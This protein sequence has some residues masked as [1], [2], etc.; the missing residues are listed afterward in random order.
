MNI[1]EV[2]RQFGLKTREITLYL[3]NLELGPTTVSNLARKTGIKR[4]TIYDIFLGLSAKGLMQQTKKGRKRLI[5]AADPATLFTLLNEKKAALNEVMPLL[6][7]LISTAGSKPSAQY[8]EGGEGLKEIYRDTLHYTGELQAFVSENII[9]LL[10]RDFSN[11]YIK[12]RHQQKIV[13]RAIGPDTSELRAYKKQDRAFLK[14]TRLVEAR[15][16]PFSIEMNIYGNKVAFM[17][18]KE[19]I[20][21]IIESNDIA[22]NMRLL[23]ELAWRGSR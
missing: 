15:K 18:F 1:E 14:Q 11:E 17:S 3:G 20:G 8:Y 19:K 7:S 13:V 6:K 10:G 23:F 16:F 5:S 21:I 22:N 12:K 9:H 2:L 4:T